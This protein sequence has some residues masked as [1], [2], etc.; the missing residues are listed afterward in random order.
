MTTYRFAI[1]GLRHHD[2]ANRLDELYDKAMG[3][4]MSKMSQ[5]QVND[6]RCHRDRPTTSRIIHWQMSQGQAIDIMTYNSYSLQYYSFEK[7]K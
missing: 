3:K 6:I 4:R 1:I 7:E 2:F 5:G